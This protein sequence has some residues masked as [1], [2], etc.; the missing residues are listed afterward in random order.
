MANLNQDPN[1]LEFDSEMP[2]EDS[3]ALFRQLAVEEPPFETGD[4]NPSPTKPGPVVNPI[5]NQPGANG[6][7]ITNWVMVVLAFIMI[8]VGA[9]LLLTDD[10]P[11]PPVS[12]PTENVQVTQ[13]PSVT[14]RPLDTATPPPP[15][16]TVVARNIE[17]LPTAASDEQLIALLTP[18]VS[19][20]GATGAIQRAE[21]P[22]TEQIA[23]TSNSFVLYRVQRGDTL[24]S[25]RRR[26]N[27]DLCTIVWSNDRNRVSPLR[28]G[29]EL[30]IPPVNG[31]YAKIRE[32]TTIKALA[33]Q[34]GVDPFDII[35]SPYNAPLFGA[36]PDSL[37]VEGLQIMVPGGNG[38]NCNIWGEG[39][40]TSGSDGV[41]SNTGQ[42]SLW[43]CSATVKGGGFP[44]QNPVGG[45][46]NF[47]QGF[48][49]SHTGVDLSADQ[50][51]PVL[52]AGLGTVVFAGW[53]QYGYG[54]TIVI[55]HGTTF[56]LYGHLSSIGVRCGQDVGQ[57][58]TIGAVGNTGR[59]S[60]PHLHFEIRDAGFNPLNPVF[61]I[62]F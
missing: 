21:A 58:Q 17:A 38:G 61:T 48:S 39:P 36:L 4:T 2:E 56:T 34:T 57:G 7:G 35:D 25:I 30:I 14:S 40:T 28:P 16:P 11:A 29:N 42:Y 62:R 23:V 43:G 19:T 50:G 59:S 22:F 52:A 44:I 60:G 9:G 46:Y 51:T 8:V 37:L 5:E 15:L 13:A 12:T 31:V 24:D 53:N 49:P 41:A 10:K 33:E 1:N 45:R 55:A 3:E 6:P 20:D 27:L 47:F 32:T 26:F 54:N 18:V